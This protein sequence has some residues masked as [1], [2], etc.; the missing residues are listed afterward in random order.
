MNTIIPHTELPYTDQEQ[1]RLNA[2][3][4]R[5]EY[6]NKIPWQYFTTVVHPSRTGHGS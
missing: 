5:I 2:R 1:L 4:S 3:S 6:F